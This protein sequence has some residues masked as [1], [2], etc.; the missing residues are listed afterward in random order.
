MVSNTDTDSSAQSAPVISSTSRILGMFVTEVKQNYKTLINACVNACGSLISTTYW[1]A[2]ITDVIAD[3]DGEGQ[4]EFFADMSI[5]GLPVGLVLSVFITVGSVYAHYILNTNSTYAIKHRQYSIRADDTDSEMDPRIALT[6]LQKILLTLDFFS[7]AADGAGPALF[8][9]S[10]ATTDPSRISKI[11]AQLI[12]SFVGSVAAFA[13]ATTCGHNMRL[14][15]KNVML[16]SLKPQD[17]PAHMHALFF[18]HELDKL[19]AQFENDPIAYAIF[20][21]AAAK[22]NAGAELLQSMNFNREQQ[23]QWLS[24]ARRRPQ[25]TIEVDGSD[26]DHYHLLAPHKDEIN[27]PSYPAA[28]RP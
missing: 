16:D 5:V 15:N 17:T 21:E 12:A 8:V 3:L 13:D 7:H 6:L 11:Y 1:I 23:L 18:S 26:E 20:T 4:D 14:H 24:P 22:L 19:K 10:L 27:S 2:Q 9:Y 25:I 28:P